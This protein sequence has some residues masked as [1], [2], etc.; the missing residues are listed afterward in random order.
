VLHTILKL[1]KCERGN[2]ESALVLIPLLTLFLIATQVQ[3]ALHGTT[4]AKIEAQDSAAKKAI[5]GEFTE[6]NSFLH[7]YSPD[8]HHN[9]DF[10]IT[11]NR[12][13]LPRLIGGDRSIEI[14]GLAIIENQR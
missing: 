7:I 1:L 9:L 2:V 6:D 13:Q 8:P 10:V 5:S 12:E 3:V 14:S 4:R 11:T